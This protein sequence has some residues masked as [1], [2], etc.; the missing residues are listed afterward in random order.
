MVLTAPVFLMTGQINAFGSLTYLGT[1]SESQ[2]G[3]SLVSVRYNWMALNNVERFFWHCSTSAGAVSAA[4]NWAPDVSDRT[5]TAKN[6]R[7]ERGQ[8][9]IEVYDR[10]DIAPFG[11]GWKRKKSK[12]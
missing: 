2:S 8:A 12:M 4:R 5:R 7:L 9:F 10:A 1:R 3:R 11:S 6:K